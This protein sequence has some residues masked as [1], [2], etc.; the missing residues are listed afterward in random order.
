[1]PSRNEFILIS[2]TRLKEAKLLYANGMYDGAVYLLG[3]SLEAALKARIC[4][5]LDSDYPD[6]GDHYRSFL[7]HKFEILI[8]LAG[9]QKQLDA[10]K[11]ANATFATNW[12]L[13]ALAWS[14]QKRY[15]TIGT[16]AQADVAD[17]IAALEDGTDG[18]L[19]WI[20]TLW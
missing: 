13:L 18:V 11:V 4:K 1:M 3:Y 16:A 17:M 5:I 12:S 7:T 14:E 15:T 9:L 10:L 19:T 20:K 6:T 8:R 2:E